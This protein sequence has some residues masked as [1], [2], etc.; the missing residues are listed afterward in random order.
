MRILLVD[1]DPAFRR[2]LSER[3][4][5]LGLSVLC[6]ANA[7]I[8]FLFALTRLDA[9]DAVLVNDDDDGRA[10][11]L[12]GRLAV[13]SEAPPPLLAY[14]GRRPEQEARITGSPPGRR[15]RNRIVSP[16]ERRDL[17][18]LI[19]RITAPSESSSA[20]RGAPSR[21]FVAQGP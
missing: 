1:P 11:W 20:S 13:A 18:A 16:R 12:Q 7:R 6:F 8:A 14:S 19:A 21:R 10:A 17:E 9:V 4:Q 15:S 5:G 3:L 2:D